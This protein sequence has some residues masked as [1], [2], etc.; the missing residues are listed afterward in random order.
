M[1]IRYLISVALAVL[2]CSI[3]QAREYKVSV[4]G[5]AFSLS[6][7][8]SIAVTGKFA[9]P[10]FGA[11]V[12]DFLVNGYVNGELVQTFTPTN[13]TWGGPV[14]GFNFGG[15]VDFTVTS[16]NITVSSR[17]G[18]PTSA[19]GDV[20][21]ITRQYVNGWLPNLRLF[22]G[23]LYLFHLDQGVTQ[24]EHQSVIPNFLFA[25][26]VPEPATSALLLI[27]LG[28]LPVLRIL[29]SKRN[30]LRGDA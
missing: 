14:G 20:L 16:E 28:S 27:G 21:L 3:A 6:G 15:D 9:A 12:Q 17:N 7:D 29:K 4:V 30:G 25:S 1:N 10:A 26:Q 23:E 18:T 19:P 11:V 8:I 24:L 22:G 13:S 5:P 2:S